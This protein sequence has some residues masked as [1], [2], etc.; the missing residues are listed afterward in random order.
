LVNIAANRCDKS[1][2]G[3]TEMLK[4]VEITGGTELNR[5]WKGT[6]ILTAVE[7]RSRTLQELER[8]STEDI[9]EN[10]VKIKNV[11]IRISGRSSR[12]K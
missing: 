7:L 12:K 9:L 3:S 8:L 10:G 2:S 11:W 5:N 6:V 1:I 4:M